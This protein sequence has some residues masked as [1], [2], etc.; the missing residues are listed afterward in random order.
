MVSRFERSSGNSLGVHAQTSSGRDRRWERALVPQR[1][2][3]RM[4]IS[5]RSRN[6]D[7]FFLL[8][9]RA[10]RSAPEGSR[11]RHRPLATDQLPDLMLHLYLKRIAATAPRDCRA[12]PVELVGTRLDLTDEPSQTRVQ[13]GF[14]LNHGSHRQPATGPRAECGVESLASGAG[15]EFG[16][17]ALI[18]STAVFASVSAA[19]PTLISHG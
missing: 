18:R 1:G 10:G 2:T 11:G 12:P 6:A 14:S 5:L 13:S 8:A 16:V 3:V 17:G 19:N 15:G 4:G 7:A 9:Q